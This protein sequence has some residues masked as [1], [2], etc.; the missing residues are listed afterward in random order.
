MCFNLIKRTKS[1]TK[2]REDKLPEAKPSVNSKGGQDPP[3]EPH[4]S[5]RKKES[6]AKSSVKLKEDKS[7]VR[8]Q[9]PSPQRPNPQLNNEKHN[10]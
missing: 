8:I 6:E 4:R 10:P 2:L 5:S 7:S 9:R 3:G 1:L